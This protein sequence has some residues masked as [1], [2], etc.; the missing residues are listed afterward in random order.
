M[1]TQPSLPSSAGGLSTKQRLSD[2]DLAK[3]GIDICKFGV[4]REESIRALNQDL[5]QS[6]TDPELLGYIKKLME[7]DDPGIAIDKAYDKLV[8][9]GIPLKNRCAGGA[10]R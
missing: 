2:V 6:A 1:A 5:G 9:A 3:L 7:T 10:N 4:V 8:G